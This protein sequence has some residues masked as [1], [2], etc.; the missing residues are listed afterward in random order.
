MTAYVAAQ[1]PDS[2]A[3]AIF[4]LALVKAIELVEWAIDA[5]HRLRYR[6][7]RL[8]TRKPRRASAPRPM[9]TVTGKVINM[10]RRKPAPTLAMSTSQLNLSPEDEQ[11][12]LEAL[13]ET[14]R[15]AR[16]E[17]PRRQAHA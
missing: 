13:A 8:F 1:L 6:V 14:R 2:I 5:V 16:A 7:R 17:R 15:M 9:K 12:V 11:L 3:M 10:P 4:L